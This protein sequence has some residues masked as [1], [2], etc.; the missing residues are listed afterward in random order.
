MDLV[1]T[2]YYFLW[3]HLKSGIY[4]NQLTHVKK[5]LNV[6]S[7]ACDKITMDMMWHI[8]TAVTSHVKDSLEFGGQ[9]LKMYFYKDN[10][11]INPTG[12]DC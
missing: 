12:C 3:G 2:F 7:S 9:K 10:L 4:N 1:I 6:I 8:Q 11:I 5:L